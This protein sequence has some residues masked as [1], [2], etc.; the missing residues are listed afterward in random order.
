MKA[1]R[2]KR[3][4]R[5]LTFF[6][7]NYNVVAPFRVLVDGTF[8]NAA[9]ANKINLREQLP[10]YLCGDVEIVTTKCVLA[11]LEALGPPVYGALVICRQFIVD[12]CPHTPC[13]TP[14]E[15]LAHLARR[16]AKKD[17]RYIIATNDDSLA[18]KLRA[19]AGTPI[20]YI[21]YNAVLLDRISQASKD[22]A[23]MK[24][25][26]NDIDTL[27]A[28]KAAVFGEPFVRIKKHKIKGPNPLS[29][30]KKKVVSIKKA[31][32][33]SVKGRRKRRSRR[34]QTVPVESGESAG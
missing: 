13:R 33:P 28:I 5:I 9:L 17:A 30:K 14:A 6:K 19:I 26:D 8:C 11:E 15:C 31:E 29:C 23:E 7:Y 20:I 16:A 4:N 34:K 3:A 10:K 22:V 21:K 27:K 12:M 18:D 24:G 25:H 2:I 1:K 32:D